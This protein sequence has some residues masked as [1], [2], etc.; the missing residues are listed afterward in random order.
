MKPSKTV[1]TS[2]KEAIENI[3]AYQRD[4]VV[5]EGLQSRIGQHPAWYA[6]E[7]DG[8]WRFGPSKFVGYARNSAD[9]YLAEYDRR[10]GRETEPALRP[11]FQPVSEG[12]ALE[13]ELR[14]QFRRFAAQFGKMPN[15]NWR[16]AIASHEPVAKQQV[17][18]STLPRAQNRVVSMPG[19]AG[20]RPV[21]RGTRVR[22][23]DVVAMIADGATAAEIIE[24]FPYITAEDVAACLRYA[25]RAADHTVIRAA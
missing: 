19:V 9:A 14:E 1:V 23:S 25:A 20:G 18:N 3:E 7:R 2:L 12:S 16:V 13:S 4:V 22:V 8:T 6:Y 5:A 24:D 11:F 15:K 21:I 17:Q 10:D